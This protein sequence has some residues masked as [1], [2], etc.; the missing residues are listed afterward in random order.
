[1]ERINFIAKELSDISQ[2]G[3]RDMIAWLDAK[4]NG[5]LTPEQLVNGCL[6]LLG[7]LDV[8]DE[9][10]TALLDFASADGE[11]NLKNHQSG[12]A[13]EQRVGNMLRM[14]AATR[15]YQLA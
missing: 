8:D 3:V 13:A 9:T 6:T 2:P 7:A 10:R 12:D 11:L 4:H 5:V 15:E 1:V 14:I